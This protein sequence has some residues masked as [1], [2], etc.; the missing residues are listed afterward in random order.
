MKKDFT[1]LIAEMLLYIFGFGLVE[2]LIKKY[3]IKHKLAIYTIIGIIGFI[4][5]YN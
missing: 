2:F 5:Y 1:Q 4:L 3:F